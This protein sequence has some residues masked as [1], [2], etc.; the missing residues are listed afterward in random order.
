MTTIVRQESR[1]L[2]R[3]TLVLSGIFVLIT[4][5]FLAAFPGFAE[6]PEVI[7]DAFPSHI[8]A[9]LGFEQMHTI[10][11]FAA[12]YIYPLVWVVFVG[13]YFAYESAGMIADDIQ[14]RRMDLL[15]SNP[16]SRESVLLQKFASLWV[17]LVILNTTLYFVLLGGVWLIDESFDPVTLL[18]VHLLSIP[19]LL[20]C[21]AIGI[22]LSVV[23]DRT[24]TAQV[25][26]IGV[27]FMLWLFEGLTHMDPDYEWV[28]GIAPTRYYDPTDIL[29]HEEYAFVDAGVLLVAFGVLLALATIA[30]VRRDI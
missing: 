9:L 10:E 21:G 29:V 30:F 23:I 7:E 24:R 16:V 28:G 3:G 27:V 26:A 17:P 14:N 4:V 15:L 6:E 1:G 12:G 22:V 11:G 2:V 5:F 13:I 18:M 20:V 19:Y 25:G 8:A